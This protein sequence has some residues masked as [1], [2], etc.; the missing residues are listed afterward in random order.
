MT[1]SVFRQIQEESIIDNETISLKGIPW[2]TVNYFWK[3]ENEK[4]KI[5]L[6]WQDGSELRRCMIWKTPTF[7]GYCCFHIEKCIVDAEQKVNEAKNSISEYKNEI[8]QCTKEIGWEKDHVARYEESLRKIL[9]GETD[10]SSNWVYD[11]ED[12]VQKELAEHKQ[13]FDALSKQ[14]SNA[15]ADKLYAENILVERE[16]ELEER[17]LKYL[18][19]VEGIQ[20]L[21][22]L[23]IAV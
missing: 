16:K 17:K 23:F 12:Y 3:T 11:R 9:S 8:K 10:S 7:E 4:Q 14:I 20:N 19:L 1:L 18:K 13:K 21:P 22:H 2:G 5:H 6:L 15:E